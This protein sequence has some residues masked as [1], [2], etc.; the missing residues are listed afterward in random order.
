MLEKQAAITAQGN[1]A[2]RRMMEK[3]EFHEKLNGV[4]TR[5]TR[6]MSGMQT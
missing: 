6:K 5:E 1:I 3:N 4:T 2:S